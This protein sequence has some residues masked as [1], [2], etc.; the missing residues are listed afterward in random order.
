MRLTLN[1]HSRMLTDGRGQLVACDKYYPLAGHEGYTFI[2]RQVPGLRIVEIKQ[3]KT[4]VQRAAI[5]LLSF[6]ADRERSQ[7]YYIN[8]DPQEPIW[9]IEHLVDRVLE[10]GIR[11]FEISPIFTPRTTIRIPHGSPY[12]ILS[13]GGSKS[14]TTDERYCYHTVMNAAWVI[15]YS[16]KDGVVTRVFIRMEVH[17]QAVMDA[18]ITSI[19]AVQMGRLV[20]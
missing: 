18:L 20:T 6:M 3:N 7:D 10:L 12:V 17:P 19:I 8:L 15:V 1:A 5:K 9:P 4:V 2:V 14:L 16:A 11:A 13:S